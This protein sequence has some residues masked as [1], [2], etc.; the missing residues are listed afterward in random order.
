MVVPQ[1]S[2]MS[3][4]DQCVRPVHATSKLFCHNPARVCLYVMFVCYVC[5]LCF[6]VMFVCYV[7]MLCSYVMFVCYVC[8]LC[9]YV[10]FVCYAAPPGHFARRAPNV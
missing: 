10:M 1:H 4:S 8:M 5:M 7:R 2:A 3:R 9:L 6:Y